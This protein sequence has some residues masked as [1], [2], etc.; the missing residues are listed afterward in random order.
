MP[1]VV[2]VKKYSWRN[3]EGEEETVSNKASPMGN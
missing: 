2:E 1:L 3:R